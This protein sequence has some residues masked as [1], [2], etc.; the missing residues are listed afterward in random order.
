MNRT[1][2]LVSALL[3]VLL[4]GRTSTPAVADDWIC[5]STASANLNFGVCTGGW[6]SPC[7]VYHNLV[8]P[9]NAY[10]CLDSAAYQ[11]YACTCA[12]ADDNCDAFIG[13]LFL[14]G[15]L[16]CSDSPDGPNPD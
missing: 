10:I 3:V 13:C 11:L 8:C 1:F 12:D 5:W 9:N 16:V 2:V 6:Y 14:R 15:V 4:T 7:P